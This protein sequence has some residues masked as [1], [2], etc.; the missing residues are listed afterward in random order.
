M[1]EISS[2]CTPIFS[3]GGK[4]WQVLC[5]DVWQWIMVS[6][7]Y[8]I[9]C[10]SISLLHEIDLN[11]KLV[12]VQHEGFQRIEMGS[13]LWITTSYKASTQRHKQQDMEKPISGFSCL[14]CS[15]SIEESCNSKKNGKCYMSIR[16]LRAV[17]HR[18]IPLA[19]KS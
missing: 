9:S 13:Y 17:S 1:E 6:G 4:I 15:Q 18:L 12:T 16:V 2:F 5:N 10:H 8:Y 19:V 11:Y 7:K 3:Q 14:F